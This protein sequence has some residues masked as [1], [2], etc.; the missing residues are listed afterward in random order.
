MGCSQQQGYRRTAGVIQGAA[1]VLWML[2]GAC[3][4][5]YAYLDPGTGSA[6]VYVVTAL[7]LSASFGI[8]G[9]YYKVVER[10]FRRRFQSQKCDLALHSE[11][12]R[13]E[14]TFMPVIRALASKNI[15]FSYFTMYERGDSFETLPPQAAHQAIPQGLV[16]YSYLNHLEAKLL[17]TT[18][19]QLDV[20]MFRRSPRVRHYCMIQHAL[21]ESRFVRPYAYDFFD[22]VLCCG[23]L[24][25]QNIRTIEGVRQLP[26]KQLL[27]TGIPHYDEL[28]RAASE[29]PARSGPTTVL[30]APSWGP[31]S[32]FTQFGT[33]FVRNIAERYNVI[34]RPHP[35]MKVSQADLYAQILAMEGVTVDTGPTPV[36]AM[37]RADIVVSDISGIAYEF[38][39]LY[40]RPVIIVDHKLAVEALEGHLLGDT[41]T[42]REHCAEFVIGV[43]PDTMNNVADKID[44]VLAMNLS[45]RIKQGR[46]TYVYNYGRGGEVAAE[47]IEGLLR[48]L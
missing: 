47:H 2:F 41:K 22:S 21:G 39:F 43:P 17:V 34:V 8:R 30:V 27:E 4:T 44:E 19:P 38:A 32:L 25:K 23:P 14:T 20:M 10:F 6:L 16:G 42:L 11:D 15:P 35:Q 5:A 33:A 31:M 9:L 40:N 48:C 7:V 3:P 12:P 1:V 37:S 36:G 29:Q 24:V 46:D 26:A 28:I 45:D 13:Y 18:T